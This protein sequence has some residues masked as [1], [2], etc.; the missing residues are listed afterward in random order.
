MAFAKKK[1]EIL[2]VRLEKLLK[3]MGKEKILIVG[4]IM[5]D[6]TF[7]GYAN[8]ISQEAPIPIIDVEKAVTSGGGASNCARNIRQ[9]VGYVAVVGV[10]GQDETGSELIRILETERINTRGIIIDSTRPT[11]R[12]IRI[13]GNGK[14]VARVDVEETKSITEE[15]EFQIVSYIRERIEE[16][17]GVIISDYGKGVITASLAQ[18]VISLAFLNNIPVFVDPK[19]A[20]YTKYSGTTVLMPNKKEAY[21]AVGVSEFK[22]QG[23]SVNEVGKSLLDL[24][25]CQYVIITLGD[26]GMIL[27]NQFLPPIEFPGHIVEVRDVVGAGDTAIS[28]LC[29]SF[30]AGATISEA[31]IFSNHLASLSVQSFGTK[32]ITRSEIIDLLHS[33]TE[34]FP[35]FSQRA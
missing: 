17:D 12:K 22:E 30:L 32:A 1:E 5:L 11:T 16:F 31:V 10:I 7:Y 23:L 20:D 13:I 3:I 4:D 6:E 21:E 18:E 27:F 25:K 35:L 28:G 2:Y 34:H 33:K 9:L 29:A 26:I 24:V 8:R 19:G 15:T 14:H